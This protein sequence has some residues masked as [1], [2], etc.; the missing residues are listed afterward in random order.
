M[1]LNF[2]SNCERDLL[3][4]PIVKWLATL[5]LIVGTLVNATG[6]YPIGPMILTVGGALWSIV[7]IA[8]REPALIVTNLVL[9]FA[10]AVGLGLHYI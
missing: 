7:A 9:V 4:I 3:V 1:E 2:I 10:G 6:Y 8:W 5:V